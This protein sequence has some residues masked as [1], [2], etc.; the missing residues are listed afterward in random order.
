MTTKHISIAK[1]FSPFPAGRYVTDGPF[2]GEAFRDQVLLPA[3]REHGDVTVDLDGTNGYGSSFLEEAFGGLVR[4]GGYSPAD[5]KIR[6][7]IKS[8]RQSY[9]VR[10]WNYIADA[11]H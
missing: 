8:Q 6:L 3:L 1:D 9:E 7:H 5:L 4:K 2:P 11:V 10:I